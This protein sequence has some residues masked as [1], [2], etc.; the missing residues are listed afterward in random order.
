MRCCY[1]L[2]AFILL[3][4]PPSLLWAET[5]VTLQLQ[6]RHQFQFA[7]Y[8]AAKEKGFYQQAG[9]DLT[10]VEGEN[11]PHK[12]VASGQVEFSISSTGLV[13]GCCAVDVVIYNPIILNL[14]F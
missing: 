13:S 1:P 11:P 10:I 12:A 14:V 4:L 2:I 7:G 3:L 5:S 8:Y 9:L 6:W